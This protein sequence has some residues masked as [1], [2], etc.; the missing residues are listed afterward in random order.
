MLKI[1]T[2][3][4]QRVLRRRIVYRTSYL[5]MPACLPWTSE[6]KARLPEGKTP[7]KVSVTTPTRH[8]QPVASRAPPGRSWVLSRAG[9]HWGYQAARWH[10]LREHMPAVAGPAGFHRLRTRELHLP[11]C[12]TPGGQSLYW[13]TVGPRGRLRALLRC[14][15]M[16]LVR[17]P[18]WH[19]LDKLPSAPGRNGQTIDQARLQP[20]THRGSHAEK[21]SELNPPSSATT[22]QRTRIPALLPPTTRII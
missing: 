14:K 8:R 16:L 10:G 1:R 4:R 15:G 3:I 19:D 11:R 21:P 5:P 7:R 20:C 18:R 22:C 17:R 6:D 13:R 2:L 9:L 12:P